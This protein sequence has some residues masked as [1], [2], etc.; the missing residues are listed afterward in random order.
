MIDGP[1]YDLRAE[2]YECFFGDR[3]EEIA[4]WAKLARP[5]GSRLIEWMCGTGELACG[6]AEAG[7]DVIGNDL[8]P[9]MLQFAEQDS[10]A[11]S[12]QITWVRGDMCNVTLPR[13]NNDFGFIAVGSFG[14]LLTRQA[15][16]QA[17]QNALRHLR[18]GGG[19]AL[20]LSLASE[21]SVP[22]SVRGPF[23]G[24]RPTRS[25]GRARKVEVRNSY[26]AASRLYRIHDVVEI[27]HEGNRQMLEYTFQ[28]RSFSPDEIEQLLAETGFVNVRMFGDFDRNPWETT[29]HQ[30]ILLAEK[31]LT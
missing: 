7:F 5:Y 20:T 29:A 10:T 16:K 22:E 2:I 3:S 28:M 18:P 21:E 30:W 25:G 8:V 13:Q 15:Q 1:A 17:L 11:R 9:E 19:L 24:L 14:H 26:N 12:L 31:P 27:E 4:G 6:L 23:Y